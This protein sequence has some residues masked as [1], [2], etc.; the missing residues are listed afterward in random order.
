MNKTGKIEKPSAIS[1]LLNLFLIQLEVLHELLLNG[2]HDG[3][4]EHEVEHVDG[5]DVLAFRADGCER[6]EQLSG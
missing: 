5:H 1:K 6:G 2:L 3:M 4:Q